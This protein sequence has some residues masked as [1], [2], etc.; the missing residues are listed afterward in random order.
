MS[1]S[2]VMRWIALPP[3]TYE[4]KVAK[5]TLFDPYD[6]PL[7]LHLR[8]K[9]TWPGCNK[10]REPANKGRRLPI[11]VL[12]R[13]EVISLMECVPGGR[14]TR[15]RNM[16]TIVVLYRAGLRIGEALHLRAKDLD[17]DNGTI[18]VLFG[19][20]QTSRTVGID[21]TG[22][23]FL[24]R[25]A[26]MRAEMPVP[27]DAP[28]LCSA[29]GRLLSRGYVREMLQIAK[30]KARI[31]KRVHPHGL[32]HTHAFELIMEGAPLPVIQLQLGHVL[33]ASTAAYVSHMAPAD[34]IARIRSRTWRVPLELLTV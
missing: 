29:R 4:R 2:S 9:Q 26:A 15:T 10:G 32:R 11:E 12:S 7:P 14:L 6:V 25:W 24:L 8:P 19:K 23:D 5:K 21:S 28:L 31:T 20:G 34:V 18:R 16:A 13:N 33:A 1:S 17:P 22:M 3:E 30:E 27:H